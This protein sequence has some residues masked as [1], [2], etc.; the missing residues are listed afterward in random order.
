MSDLTSRSQAAKK[1]AREIDAAY[2]EA[3]AGGIVA[4]L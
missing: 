2:E 3:E 4:K 1:F